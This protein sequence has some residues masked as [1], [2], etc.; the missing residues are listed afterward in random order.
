LL[1][2][3]RAVLLLVSYITSREFKTVVSRVF[4][5][6]EKSDAIILGYM[7]KARARRKPDG[8]EVTL[9]DKGAERALRAQLRAV[10]PEDAVFGE[11]YG[12]SLARQGRCWLVDPIDGTA[13]YVLGMPM[14]GTLLSLLID[15]EPVFGC[16][17]LPALRETTYAANGL[18]CWLT[19]DGG[20]SQRV[21]VASGQALSAAKVGMTVFKERDL[22]HK[23][24]AWAVTE[25]SR[26]VGRFR[27]VGD[28]V[29]YPLLCR[30]ALDGA[31]DPLMKPWDIAAL[32]PC[33]LEAGGS[34]SDLN[35]ETSQIV[36][37]TSIVAAS[38]DKLR[39]QICRQF[40]ESLARSK[41]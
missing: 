9:A 4:E 28:C 24:G 41:P 17:H 38:S 34:I 1:H 36:E 35:G 22:A 21:H 14:F 25:L 31:I 29:Q 18:G 19:R 2:Q 33:V 20:R 5:A 6:L 15:G 30:G 11:E 8:S 13:S 40:K 10:W 26:R 3:Q 32:V 7:H 23:P 16:I 37:R 39:R 12:G 27:L